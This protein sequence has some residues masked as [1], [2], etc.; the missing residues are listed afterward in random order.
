[1]FNLNASP[2]VLRVVLELDANG[3]V[4]RTWS[5]PI[6]GAPGAV[7]SPPIAPA[8]RYTRFG[9]TEAEPTPVSGSES[10][11]IADRDRP[12][13]AAAVA[14]R[15]V[16]GTPVAGT[17][18]AELV[19]RVEEALQQ[20]APVHDELLGMTDE[21]VARSAGFAP[22]VA[23]L[24]AIGVSNAPVLVLAHGPRRVRQVVK[25]VGKQRARS[26]AALVVALLK[27]APGTV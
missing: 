7:A 1:M 13:D 3:Q 25:Y 15:P 21:Q 9:A 14:A 19:E 8:V 6:S 5:E 26:P 20:D 2:A 12:G 22:A 4:V 24:R 11:P 18:A 27:R 16:A 10:T 23:Q 17:P